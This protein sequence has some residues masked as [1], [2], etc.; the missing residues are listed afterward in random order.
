MDHTHAIIAHREGDAQGAILQ[1]EQLWGRLRA[2][3][4]DDRGE[5]DAGWLIGTGLA[6]AYAAVGRNRD[7]LALVSSLRAEIIGEYG[8]A[9][10]K[11]IKL[12]M[13]AGRV[14]VH[15]KDTA[16]AV[17]H[18]QE[19][20]ARANRAY[21]PVS[22]LTAQAHSLLAWAH[23]TADHLDEAEAAYRT[24]LTAT[25]GA[26]D[27]FTTRLLR[28][29]AAIHLRRDEP[30]RAIALLHR[31]CSV[32]EDVLPD[33][34]PELAQMRRQLADTEADFAAQREREVRRRASAG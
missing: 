28:G 2:R 13:I 26:P 15:R 20:A 9:H 16:A 33:A 27:H 3:P 18:M 5:L 22:P 19:A 25:A 23:L 34:S 1:L 7:A 29:L 4:H 14:A 32:G 8:E 30:Q 17:M 21:G 31:A 6:S 10:P 11:T 12:A 24:A